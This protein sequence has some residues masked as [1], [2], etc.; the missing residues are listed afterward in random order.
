MERDMFEDYFTYWDDLPEDSGFELFSLTHIA[1][2]IVIT[3][4][5]LCG[6]KF[7]M[8]SGVFKRRKIR[9]VFAGILAG[10]ELYKDSVLIITGNMDFQYLPFQLCGLAVIIEILYLIHPGDFLGEIMCIVALPG[11]FAALIFPDW[12][13]YPVVNFMSLHSFIIHGILVMLPIMIMLSGEYIPRISH[14][15]RVLLFFAVVVPVIYVINIWQDTNFMFLRWPS[16]SSPFEKIYA[17]RGYGFYMSIYGIVVVL[18][19]LGMYGIAK[20]LEKLRKR[21]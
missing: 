3:A 13:R 9:L 14:I 4:G 17:K 15:Y 16:R 8:E 2:L 7:Y 19:V 21:I 11:A 5:I 18:V 20:L 6:I 1:W 10:M 12:T